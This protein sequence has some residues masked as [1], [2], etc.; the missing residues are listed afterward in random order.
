MTFVSRDMGQLIARLCVAAV[1]QYSGVTKALD[2]LAG[3]AEVSALGLPFPEISLGLTILVQLGGSLA[4]IFGW[5]IP[6]AA[7]ALGGFTI[8]ATLLAHDFWNYADVSFQRQL[9]TALE[10]LA[11]VGG[12]F[13]LALLGP[14]R[15]RLRYRN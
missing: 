12:F 4:L 8:V 2:W 3:V 7:A 6:V 15:Y 9:T 14:G 13:A 1:F 11:I 10:H 5:G